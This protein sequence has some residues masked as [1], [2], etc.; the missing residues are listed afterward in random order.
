MNEDIINVEKLTE[1][2]I[3]VGSKFI[4]TR[5]IRGMN[6]EAKIEVVQYEPSKAF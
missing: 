4:E 1:G 2:S 5:V 3:A 6:A